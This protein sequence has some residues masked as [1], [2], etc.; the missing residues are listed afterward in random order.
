MN[1]RSR[2]LLAGFKGV[3]VKLRP[4]KKEVIEMWNRRKIEDCLLQPRIQKLIL[5]L[6]PDCTVSLAPF[7]SGPV[8]QS[9]RE[10]E[11]REVLSVIKVVSQDRSKSAGSNALKSKKSRELS[12]LLKDECKELKENGLDKIPLADQRLTRCRSKSA[13]MKP[14]KQ[15]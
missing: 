9:E 8:S 7:S 11:T 4:L 5:R 15:T 14:N 1:K 13:A 10:A 6:S 12:Q 3:K 2:L